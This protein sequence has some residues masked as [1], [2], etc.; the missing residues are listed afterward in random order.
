MDRSKKTIG[1]SPATGEPRDETTG[2]RKERLE[3]DDGRYI[4]FY[5]FDEDEEEKA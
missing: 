1:E 5:S 3:K 2:F 4:I